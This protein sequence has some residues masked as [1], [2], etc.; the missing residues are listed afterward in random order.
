MLL[1][2]NHIETFNKTVMV[3][4]TNLSTMKTISRNKNPGLEPVTRFYEV[5]DGDETYK[6]E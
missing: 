3:S 6:R 2:V 1:T 5:E 4:K